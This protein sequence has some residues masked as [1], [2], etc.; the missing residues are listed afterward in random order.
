MTQRD[1]LQVGAIDSIVDIVASAIAFDYLGWRPS[2]AEG[3]PGPEGRP[4][5]VA[6]SRLPMGR[7]I[8]RGAAHGPLPCPAPATLDVLCRC[9]EEDSA[10]F[11]L[12]KTLV[13]FLV[14]A[15]FFSSL[16]SMLARLEGLSS[17][18]SVSWS[19]FPAVA[20]GGEVRSPWLSH[21]LLRC[22]CRSGVPTFDA[23]TNGELVT[24][25]GACLVGALANKVTSWPAMVPERAAY[26]AGTKSWADRPNLLRLVLGT[27][28]A[29]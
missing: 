6:V 11:H 14:L 22:L 15:V 2:S 1:E 17:R 5:Q 7:G 19:G 28:L 18:A 21:F 20:V 9:G 4:L 12:C 10:W 26:G 27:P 23:G 25:T 13:C 29:S 3:V 8:I 16:G 24:P